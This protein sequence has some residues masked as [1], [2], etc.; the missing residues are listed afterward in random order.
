VIGTLG[1]QTRPVQDVLEEIDDLRARGVRELF[2]LDQTFGASER[3]GLELCRAL[4]ERGDLSWTAFTRPDTAT[5]GLLAAMAAAGCHTLIL[6]VETADDAALERYKKG[7]TTAEVRAACTR[8]RAHGIRTVGTFILG[9]PEETTE[10]LERTLTLALELELDFMSL[11][12]A[13]PRFG[14][15]FRT[16]ALE[17][18]LARR[19]DLVMDQAGSEAFLP[20]A[21][22]DR[23]GVLALKQRMVRRFYLRPSYL[24]RRLRSAQS[25]YELT[26]HAREGVALLR[27]NSASV[28]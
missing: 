10:S 19:E 17:L 7:V 22:L 14:T 5:D 24:W 25:W 15:P 16:R 9:L 12:V 13:V 1:F 23:S 28:S 26:A 20:T 8:M 11:N 21:T 2:F 4:A 3:R 6:G 27:R 18:G